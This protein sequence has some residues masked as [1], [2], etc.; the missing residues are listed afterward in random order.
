MTDTTIDA[1]NLYVT[2][3]SI[4]GNT[5]TTTG[6]E[7]VIQIQTTKIEYDLEGGVVVISIP[8]SKGNRGT[9][10]PYARVIDLKR[11]K[12]VVS[13]QGFLVDESD[14]RALTKRDNLI[15]LSKSGGALTI[16]WG[17]DNY[18]T[19]WKPDDDPETNTGAFITKT[20]FT[21]TA[22]SLSDEGGFSGDPPPEKNI[23]INIQFVRGKDM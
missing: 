20:K 19:I 12:E 23:A 15:S 14:S 22:G 11:I 18:Q 9:Q 3:G 6:S 13:I 4:S 5:I 8:V 2:D 17:Q 21:E 7:I 1:G 10:T 16:V